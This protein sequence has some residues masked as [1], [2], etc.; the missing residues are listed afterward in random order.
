MTP[1]RSDKNLGKAYNDAFE[2]VGDDDWICLRDIDT[3]FLT[4]SGPLIIEMYVKQFPDAGILTCFTN[5]V[6]NRL[7]MV[8]GAMSNVRDIAFHIGRAEAIQEPAIKQLKVTKLNSPIS[9]MLMVISKRTWQDIPF[10]EGIG[11]LGVDTE[12]SNQVYKSG[13]KILLMN[14]LYV[15]HTYRLMQGA[16]NKK[17]LL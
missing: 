17:H 8:H 4:P 12:F 11:C 13:K 10:M 7:Q 3:M 15:W 6:G 2:M 1:Y 16:Q 9:G 14:A 5:R